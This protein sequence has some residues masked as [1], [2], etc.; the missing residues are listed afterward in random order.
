MKN[1]FQEASNQF[2][3]LAIGSSGAWQIDIDEVLKGA[4]CYCVQI[5]GPSIYLSFQLVD[6]GIIGQ[7]ID[8]LRLTLASVQNLK[9]HCPTNRRIH[10]LLEVLAELVCP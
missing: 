1:S 6:L 5:Q 2:G 9:K 8:F 4:E 3:L 7:A 10:S